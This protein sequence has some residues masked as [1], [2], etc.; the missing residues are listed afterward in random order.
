M[1]LILAEKGG[2][3]DLYEFKTSMVYIASSR[4]ARATQ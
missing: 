4:L 1:A 2:G 3:E